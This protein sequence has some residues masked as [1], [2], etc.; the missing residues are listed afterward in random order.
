VVAD[1]LSVADLVV[2]ARTVEIARNVVV[3]ALAARAQ[4][5]LLT[6]SRDVSTVASVHSVESVLREARAQS[7]VIVPSGLRDGMV[8]RAR[9]AA[10]GRSAEIVGSVARSGASAEM[11]SA[12]VAHVPRVKLAAKDG[13]SSASVREIASR[14]IV[15]LASVHQVVQADGRDSVV[16]ASGSRDLVVPDRVA[17]DRVALDHVALD[18]VALDHVALVHVALVHGAVV[19]VRQDLVVVDAST[20]VRAAHPG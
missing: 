4:R 15:N 17:L 11:A 9:S 1:A 6:V 12:A 18:R 7:E 19:L 10:V 8:A 3:V 2:I 16:G 20:V 5:V 14:W 13:L